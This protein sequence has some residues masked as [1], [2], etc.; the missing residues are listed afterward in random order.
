MFLI[1]FIKIFRVLNI[2]LWD[3]VLITFN[4][5][6]YAKVEKQNSIHA[7]FEKAYKIYWLSARHLEKLESLPPPVGQLR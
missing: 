4:K 7:F 6:F 3:D 2:V 5:Y 1:L